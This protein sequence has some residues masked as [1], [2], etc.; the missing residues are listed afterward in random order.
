MS[1]AAVCMLLF[2]QGLNAAI[3]DL[4]RTTGRAGDENKQSADHSHTVV[5]TLRTRLKDATQVG[6][7]SHMMGWQ[8]A[9]AQCL[10]A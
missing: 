3:A 2:V 5:D 10:T 7:C 8:A 6:T 1:Y 9:H 4:Q